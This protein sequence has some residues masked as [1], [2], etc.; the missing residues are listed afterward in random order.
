MASSRRVQVPAAF[1]PGGIT[2][3]LLALWIAFSSSRYFGIT[4]LGGLPDVTAE[5]LSFGL[6][7]G[8]VLVVFTL[9]RQPFGVVLPAE[10]GL[11]TLALACT[12][13]AYLHGGFGGTRTADTTNLLSFSLVY[14]AIAFMIVVRTR[15][16]RQDLVR[17]GAIMAL[18]AIYLGVTAILERTPYQWALLPP[19]IGDPSQG[20]HW[21][22]SRGP[23]LNS[24]FN[25][26]V[27][28]QLVPIL[29]LL[30]HLA[31]PAGRAVGVTGLG[32]LGIGVYLTDTRACLLSLAVVTLLGSV[33]R[34]PSRGAYR[35]LLALI[36]LGGVVRL[37]VGGEVV[38]RLEEAEPVD[39][40]LNLM[41]ASGEM[42]LAHPVFGAGFG[43][44]AE[45]SREY[46]NAARIFGGLSYQ[47]GWA[48]VGSHSTFLTPLAEMGL[49]VGGLY[50]VL[51]VRAVWNGLGPPVG[52]TPEEREEV[53]GLLVCC[54]LVGVPFLVGGLAADFKPVLT[55]NALFWTVAGFTERHRRL[56]RL[57]TSEGPQLAGAPPVPRPATP[58]PR[59]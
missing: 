19:E 48:E 37:S 38:P 20:I 24:A 26:T 42:V 3:L 31:G 39:T 53:R 59:R 6:L 50:V 21:G 34:G 35:A 47:K 32:L 16:S 58:V 12:A 43:T 51:A 17:F 10:V 15:T 41:L 30:I 22:R 25:G 27:M 1:L 29:M 7:L 44:F 18:F 9:R 55:P 33:L 2:L 45:L 52:R 23:W 28:A 5:R 56:R 13:S 57:A 40:R 46:Y 36:V 54:L 14:P 4:G 49:L 11:W 8:Y